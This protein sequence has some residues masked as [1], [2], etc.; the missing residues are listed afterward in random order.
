M[1]QRLEGRRRVLLGWRRRRLRLVL[2]RRR[3]ALEDLDFGLL[4][5]RNNAAPEQVGMRHQDDPNDVDDHRRT[6]GPSQ[7]AV[8]QLALHRQILLLKCFFRFQGF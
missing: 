8:G 5:L 7:D 4:Y 3:R 1:R 6:E 2:R